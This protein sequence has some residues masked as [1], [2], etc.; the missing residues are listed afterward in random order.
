[1][2][3]YN[4]TWSPVIPCSCAACRLELLSALYKECPSKLWRPCNKSSTDHTLM[5]LYQHVQVEDIRKVVK[6]L[7]CWNSIK[8]K[9]W[10]KSMSISVVRLFFK[11]KR[12]CYFH[13]NYMASTKLYANYKNA[14]LNRGPFDKSVS[15]A[16]TVLHRM[17]SNINNVRRVWSISEQGSLPST[18][19]TSIGVCLQ[20]PF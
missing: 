1:M 4:T 5:I 2:S 6:V 14:L 8:R 19:Q 10:N 3:K 17:I 16:G 12:R 15:N 18:L 11:K 9:H 13:G 7:Q 20:Q